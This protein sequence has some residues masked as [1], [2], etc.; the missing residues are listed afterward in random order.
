MF[1]VTPMTAVFGCKVQAG[2]ALYYSYTANNTHNNTFRFNIVLRQAVCYHDVT[3][4]LEHFLK[5]I[6]SMQLK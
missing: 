1:T 4:P 6:P 5:V 2:C 3:V